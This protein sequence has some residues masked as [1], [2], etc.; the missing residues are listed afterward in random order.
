VADAAQASQLAGFTVRLP[1]SPRLAPAQQDSSAFE[2]TVDRA[3]AQVPLTRP[4][5]GP[6]CR[7]R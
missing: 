2:F 4:A 5:D 3:R 6:N 1:S 7:P